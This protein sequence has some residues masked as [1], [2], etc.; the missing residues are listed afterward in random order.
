MLAA[1]TA[2]AILPGAV[3]AQQEMTTL[4]L[5]DIV[6]TASGHAQTL[7]DAP[8]TISV[9]DGAEIASK[10]YASVVDV[11]RDV[12][13][14]VVNGTSTRSGAESISIRGMGQDYVLMLVDG[15]PLGNS[16]EATYNGYG[17]GQITSYL[18][19][20][21]AIERIEVIRGPMSSLYGTAAS[22]GVINVITRPVAPE[23]AGEL[24]LGTTLRADSDAGDSHEGR[25]YLSG[26]VIADRVGLALFGSVNHRGGN[27]VETARDGVQV[28][29]VTRRS[30]GARLDWR[31]TEMQDLRFELSTNTSDTAS[32]TEAGTIGG[33]DVNRTNYGATHNLRWGGGQETTSFLTYEDVR[34]DNAGMESAYNQLTLNSRTTFSWGRHDLTAGIEYRDEETRHNPGRIPEDVDPVMTRWQ[35][36]L[37]GED[38]YALTDDLTFTLGLRHDHN[39]RYGAHFTP[40]A[41]AVWHAT[42]TLTLKGGVSGGYKTPQLKQADSSIFEPAGRGAGW[43]QGNTLLMP[44]ESINYEIGM[45]WEA[46]SGVQLGLTAYRTDFTNKIDRERICSVADDIPPGVTDCRGRDWIQQYVNRDKARLNGIELTADYGIGDFDLSFNYTYADSE[47]T[48]GPGAGDPFNSLPLHVA[49]FGVEWQPAGPLSLWGDLQ[50]RSETRETSGDTIGAHVIATVGADYQFNDRVMGTAAVYNA[51]NRTFGSDYGD[52]RR[53]YLGLTSSF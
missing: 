50:Y 6:I 24:T 4:L 39:E 15:K 17:S 14:V 1:S 47:I 41:Y 51:T 8:A 33:I 21:S 12:P 38:N 52:G 36:A 37:F 23:W 31:L 13:G 3:L 20:P 44:E 11:L 43:D 48:E 18:P 19:P 42:P 26:P 10:P 22:G 7:P 30:L 53:L 35:W 25:F 49:N 45:A 2:L 34:F 46:A 28:Q 9:I 5:D 16:S 32:L 27:V 29:D 40:R